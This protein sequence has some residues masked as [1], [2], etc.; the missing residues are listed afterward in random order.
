MRRPTHVLLPV[1]FLLLAGAGCR[2]AARP[3]LGA[4]RTVEAGVPVAL[5]PQ[6]K[7]GDALTWDFGDGTPPKKAPGG[8]HAFARAGRYTVRA[9]DGKT[10][11]ARVVL[12]VVPRPA[13]RAVPHDAESAMFLPRMRGALDALVAFG[14]AALGSA[15]VEEF[16]RTTPLVQL[17]LTQGRADGGP[18]DVEEGLGFFSLEGFSGVTG[19]VGVADEAAAQKAVVD[20]LAREGG[21]AEQ[22]P[23]GLTRVTLPDGQALALF[24][25]RGYLYLTAAPAP[26]DDAPAAPPD[27]AALRARVTGATQGLDANPRVP[28]LLPKVAPGLAYFY[29]G[30]DASRRAK[31][32]AVEQRFDGALL[33]VDVKSEARD[34]R[35]LELDGFF[36]SRKP[37][38]AGRPA[39][40]VTMLTRAPE[41][42]VAALQVSLPPEEVADLLFGEAGSESRREAE[43]SLQRRG[44]D[45]QALIGSLRGD[46]GALVY[47]DAAGF[48]QNLL[49][50][51]RRPEP[52]GTL[53]VEAGL[54][55]ADAVLAWV[56]RLVE[57]SPFR[58]DRVKEKGATR[59]RAKFFGQGLD[60]AVRPDGLA[61]QAGSPQP[62]RPP[63]DVGA[64]LRERFGG[65]AF[66]PGH[67][68]LMVDVSRLLQELD[69]V[70]SVPGVNPAQLALSQA[71]AGALLDALPPVDHAFVDF[72]PEEGGGRLKGRVV[73]RAR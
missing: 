2:R 67:L 59:F 45:A 35:R 21:R 6:D 61:L 12:T 5:G 20:A 15:A 38:F 34:D 7:G 27:F 3:D 11:L 55:R 52:R 57:E 73:L 26:K 28:A 33:S 68:S 19:F 49:R 56:D 62:V 13:L 29:I 44:I 66:G 54:T 53:L 10:E 17:V 14:E 48:Y 71:A 43:A 51:S 8:R 47:A 37:L 9:L 36:S 40:P 39:P 60:L 30:A 42:P 24:T 69:A 4:D 23:D 70:T 41:G 1:L 16:V 65:G 32:D 64:K 22:G 46:V 18:L 50:G 31:S 63:T 58:V 72:S 25:D